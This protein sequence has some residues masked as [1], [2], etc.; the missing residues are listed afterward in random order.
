VGT[1]YIFFEADLRDRFVQALAARALDC[2]VRDDEIEGL[3]VDLDTEPADELLQ[4]LED[5][6]EALMQE[7]MLRAEDRPGWGSHQVVSLQISRADGSPAEVRLPPAVARPL[8][9]RFSVDEAREL[10]TA[11]AHSLEHPQDG[12]LCRKDLLR[13]PG[14]D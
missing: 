10:V 11:I 1:S 12:P 9:E 6:Y 13:T 2:H 8:L 4:A 14:G 5:E 3:V 7:Q